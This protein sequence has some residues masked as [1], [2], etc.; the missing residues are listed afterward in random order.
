MLNAQRRVAWSFIAKN[1]IALEEA[2]QTRSLTVCRRCDFL[3]T[4]F[5]SLVQQSDQLV[6]ILGR[7]VGHSYCLAPIVVMYLSISTW[8][9]PL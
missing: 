1:R 6:S 3:D 4:S 9:A 8:S 7:I 5:D 2:K